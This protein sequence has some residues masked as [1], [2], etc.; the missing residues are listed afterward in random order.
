MSEARGP[1]ALVLPTLDYNRTFGLA[2]DAT[3]GVGGEVKVEYY[4]IPHKENMKSSLL[5]Q[6]ADK[7]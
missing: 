1:V 2:P 3:A 7:K 5:F 4:C 6:A